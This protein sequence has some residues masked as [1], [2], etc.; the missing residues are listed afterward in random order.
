MGSGEPA[1]R[2]LAQYDEFFIWFRA[3][4][5]DGNLTYQQFNDLDYR[6]EHDPHFLERIEQARRSL[7]AGQGVR[8][9]EIE[10]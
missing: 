4:I 5:S 10:E 8:L 1:C 6:L 2:M 3:T 7:R 9:E